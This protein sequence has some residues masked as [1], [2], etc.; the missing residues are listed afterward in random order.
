MNRYE[1]W[2]TKQMVTNHE[3]QTFTEEGVVVARQV[4][5]TAEIKSL[6]KAVAAI[7]NNPGPL[8]IQ[9]SDEKNPDGFIEDFRRWNDQKAIEDIARHSSLPHI[10]ALL[11]KSSVVRFYHDHILVRSQGNQQRTPW[12]QDQPYYDIDGT[13]TVSFWLPLDPVPIEE[14]IEIVAGTHTGSWMMPRTFVDKEARWFPEGS[15]QEVPDI[16]KDRDSFPIRSWAL[17]PGDAICFSFLSL[18]GAPGSDK[19]RRTVSLR[20]IGDDVYRT[21]RSWQTSPPF[22]ELKDPKTGLEDG[23]GLNHPLFPVVWP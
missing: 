12:H 6:K 22:P 18:H 14:S 9:L 3:I 19:G 17:E 20:Y 7:R 13:Q 4:L 15:L 10:A 21:Q 1:L 2:F 5:T 23:E 8:S 11:T 16:D